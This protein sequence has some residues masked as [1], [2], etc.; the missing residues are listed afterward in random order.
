MA[1]G[2]ERRRRP[3]YEEKLRSLSPDQRLAVELVE[4]GVLADRVGTHRRQETS[5]GAI[6]DL[7]GLDEWGLLVSFRFTDEGE[8]EFI[9][10]VFV[11]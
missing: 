9:D 4:E 11:P 7:S 8:P 10:F 5:G 6:V 1:P 3:S 2:P